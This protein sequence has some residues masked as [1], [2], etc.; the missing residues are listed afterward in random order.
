MIN[1]FKAELLKLRR[2]RV[3]VAVAGS[4]LAFAALSAIV[5]FL[6]A[7]GPGERSAARGATVAEL[8]QA[9]GATEAF[10]IGASF[11]GILVLVLFI[12]NFAGEFSQGTF[13]T[14]L[15]RQPRRVGLLAGKM[16]A[17]LVFAAG[18]LALTELLTVAASALLA[19]S[20]DVATSS[21][22]GAD[23]LGHAAGD[24]GRALLGVAAWGSLGMAL[25]VF[26]RSI[27]VALGIGIVW[28]GPLEHLTQDAWSASTQWFPG[29]LLEAL[30]AG[31]TAD[32]SVGRA[33]AL[34]GVYVALAAGA[35]ALVF[36][37]RDV[38]A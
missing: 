34:V 38:T 5:V 17:L 12:A 27:P 4:A 2:R 20:Q 29:L 19:P 15:M 7:A 3:A 26:V 8:S 14:L 24:Y 32:V 31:G 28:S 36:A 18:V 37:R 10:S 25:A 33:L 13:R 9:G 16:A 30:A 21:W 1:T 6:S 22:F 35:A 23:G 11:I